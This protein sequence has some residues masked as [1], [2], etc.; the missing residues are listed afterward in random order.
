MTPRHELLLST[1]TFGGLSSSAL[2]LLL[3]VAQVVEVK[4]GEAFF[5]EGD[6]ADSLFILERGEVAIVKSWGGSKCLL[7]QF[8]GG[9][10]FGEM[11]VLDLQPR[12]ASAVAITDASALEISAQSLHQ[13]YQSDIK[14]FALIFMNLARELSRRLR[15]CDDRL[16]ALYMEGAAVDDEELCLCR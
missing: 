1:P 4:S 15:I 3:S 8:T 11:A 6:N 10:C 7:A 14:Q 5:H 9:D 2:E 12:S 13:L 16:F